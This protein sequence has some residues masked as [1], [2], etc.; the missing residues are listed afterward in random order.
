MKKFYEIIRAGKYP[1]KNL[2]EQDIQDLAKN[3]DPNFQEAPVKIGHK[4]NNFAYAWIDELKAEGSKLM[5][6]F[7]EVTGEL[8]QLSAEKK[9]KRHSAEIYSNL[10][11][12]GIYLKG[13]AMLGA[14]A[15]AVKGMQP[16]EFSEG[17][18]ESI[19]FEESPSFVDDFSFEFY[20]EKAERLSGENEQLEA[21]LKEEKKKTKSFSEE[22]EAIQFTQ[23]QA[24]FEAF[25]DQ[26]IEE[27]KFK[28][29]L[30]EK[31]VA[32]FA[33]LDSIEVEEGEESPLDAF[34]EIIKEFKEQIQFGEQF[35]EGEGETTEYTVHEL[36]A[37]AAEYQEEQRKAGKVVSTSAAVEYVK[38]QKNKDS[39]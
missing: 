6:S 25:L 2:T 11:G 31:A 4:G 1:Q 19:E 15:P 38:N 30:R 20:K 32:L 3:Y 12:K 24:D 13:L 33:H 37:K 9:L 18:S 5:A 28:P 27:G 21:S 39:K 17:E 26:G 7:K 23:R 16:I 34:K 22:N 8:K 36:A 29:V 14:E 10:Q 35:T